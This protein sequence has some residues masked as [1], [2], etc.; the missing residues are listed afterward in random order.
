VRES[1]RWVGAGILCLSIIGIASP[2]AAQQTPAGELSGGYQFFSGKG[3]GE[4]EDW[5]N[6]S[7][8]W[9]ADVAGNL[10]NS[11]GI[12]GQVSGNYKHF[13][14]EDFD[15]KIH[16]FMG[17]LRVGSQGPVRGFGQVLVGA[18]NFKAN[19]NT[20]SVSETDFAIQLGAG[21]TMM[22]GGGVGLRVGADYL[23]IRGKDDGDLSN[24]EDVNGFRFVAG[25]VFGLGGR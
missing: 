23:R 20:D 12:V 16:T 24:G 4:D 9:Y 22:G 6:F 10:T 5:E 2:A 8:G 11:V 7:K 1:I 15:F 18:A 21:V 14:D 3:E 19:D 13:D 25:V 17:G